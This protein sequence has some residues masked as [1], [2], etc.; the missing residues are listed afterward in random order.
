[1]NDRSRLIQLPSQRMLLERLE[2][3][4]RFGSNILLVHGEPGAGKSALAESLL[5]SADFANQAWLSV[6]SQS[7]DE[8][9]REQLLQQLLSDPLFNPSDPLFDSLSRNLEASEVPLLLVIDQAERLSKQFFSE[10]FELIEKYPQNYQHALNI[11]L[12]STLST[13]QLAQQ[14]YPGFP[15]LLEIDIPAL[16]SDEASLLAQSLFERADYQASV[17]N[18]SAVEQ[19]IESALGNPGAICQIVEQIISGAAIMSDEQAPKRKPYLVWGGIVV[20]VAAVAGLLV[21]VLNNHSPASSPSVSA[22]SGQANVSIPVVLPTKQDQA[23]TQPSDN[24]QPVSNPQDQDQTQSLPAPVTEQSINTQSAPEVGQKRVVVNDQV[25]EQ[26]VKAQEQNASDTPTQPKAAPQPKAKVTDQAKSPSSPVVAK[27]KEITSAAAPVAQTPQRV[28]AEI[29]PQTGTV[30]SNVATDTQSVLNAKP[31][32]HYTL[33]LGAFSSM[34]AAQEFVQKS[35]LNGW[36]YPFQSS[37]RILYKV[38]SGDYAVRSAA[39][40][41]Q[42]QFKA[43]GQASLIKSFRQVQFELQH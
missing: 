25:V 40:Q 15:Q 23:A 12:F 36:I 14:T 41:A 34:Q 19:R 2:T 8:L 30:T 35:S 28:H 26:L 17:E 10:L 27:A 11:V 16:T 6:D 29:A 13:R 43:K 21:Q 37:S 42:R 24:S 7:N 38:I 1:M 5:D 4:V 22:S 33:Q 18:K 39:L 3:Q 31:A 20:L 9:L 32:N